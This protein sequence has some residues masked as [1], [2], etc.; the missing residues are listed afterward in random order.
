MKLMLVLGGILLA[1]ATA[2]P[3]LAGGSGQSA[4]QSIL[5]VQIGS[6][7]ASPSV[8]ASA[9]VDAVAPVCVASSCDTGSAATPLAEAAAGS[10]GG[11]AASAAQT[12]RDS[13]GVVQ[14]GSATFL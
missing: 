9:P 13:I 11:S 6:V 10:T 3:A 1:L 8:A 2:S 5:A 14:V 12:S 7:A 4:D